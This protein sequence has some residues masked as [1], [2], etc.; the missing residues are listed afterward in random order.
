MPVGRGVDVLDLLE[1][2][3]QAERDRLL[4]Q[5]GQLAAGDLVGVDPAGRGR[6]RPDSNGA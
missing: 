2:V 5:V 4:A 3:A 6:G 1:P